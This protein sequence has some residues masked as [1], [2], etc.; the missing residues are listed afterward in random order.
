MEK[1]QKIAKTK[2]YEKNFFVFNKQ[3]KKQTFDKKKRKKERGK[4]QLSFGEFF[5]K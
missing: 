2:S 5:S 4:Q 1:K 3:W